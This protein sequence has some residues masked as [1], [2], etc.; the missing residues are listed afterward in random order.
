MRNQVLY[1][2]IGAAALFLVNACQK[3]VVNPPELKLP[4]TSFTDVSAAGDVVVVDY[5]LTNGVE[6]SEIKVDGDYDWAKVT[7]IK[8]ASIEVTVDPNETTEPRT[9]EFTVS[10]PGVTKDLSFSIT[11]EAGEAPAVEATVTIEPTSAEVPAEGVEDGVFV[12]TISPEGLSWEDL[13]CAVS[14]AEG[15]AGGWATCEEGDLNAD[16][17]ISYSVEPNEGEARTA[18]VTVSYPNAEDVVFTI[19]QKAAGASAEYDHEITIEV[20]IADEYS[21]TAGEDM[22]EDSDCYFFYMSEKPVD[23]GYVDGTAYFVWDIYTP[24]GT[25]GVLPAGEYRSTTDSYVP[26]TFSTANSYVTFIGDENIIYFSEGTINVTKDG[27]VYTFDAKLTDINGETYHAVY[28]GEM[29]FGGGD[30]PSDEVSYEFE[31]SYLTFYE[32]EGQNGEDNFFLALSDMPFDA[33]GYE[34][35]GCTLANFDIYAAAGTSGVLPAGTYRFDDYNYTEGTF[36]VG[37]YIRTPDKEYIYFSDGSIE[38]TKSGDD[39]VFEATLTGSKDGKTYKVSYTGPIGEGGGDEPG[40][41]VEYETYYHYLS[42]YEG[43]E[44]DEYYLSLSDMEFATDWGTGAEGSV[45]M[46][47][48]LFSAPGTG[49]VLPVGEY[50]FLNS[51]ESVAGTFNVMSE[52]TLPNGDRIRFME[53]TLDV[54]KDAEGTYTLE[55]NLAGADGVDYRITYTGPIGESSGDDPD[56]ADMTFEISVDNMTYDDYTYSIVPSNKE[57]AYIHLGTPKEVLVGYGAMSEDGVI[58]EYVLH[59]DVI[60]Q[61]LQMQDYRDKLV[62]T[63]DLTDA[64]PL[65]PASSSQEVVVLCYGIDSDDNRIT[66]VTTYKFTMQ[67]MPAV[68]TLDEETIEAGAGDYNGG[69]Y[70]SLGGDYDPEGTVTAV[71]EN[72][73]DWVRATVDP[74]ERYIEVSVDANNKPVAR[75]ATITVSHPSAAESAVLTVNQE[76]GELVFTTNPNW[77]VSYKGRESGEDG[78]YDVTSVVSTDTERFFTAVYGVDSY[79]TYGIE[80]IAENEVS[81]MEYYYGSAWIQYYSYTSSIEERWNLFDPGTYYVI[82]IGIDDEGN[83]TGLYQISD[84]FEPEQLEASD[85]YNKWLGRWTVT[86]SNGVENVLEI[87][88]RSADVS[89]TV[90]GWQ[91]GDYSESWPG[92]TANFNEDGSISFMSEEYGSYDTGQYGVGTLGCFGLIAVNDQTSTVTGGSYP[93]CTVRLTSDSTAEAVGEDITL[94][95]GNTYDIIGMEYEV[96]LSGDYEGYILNFTA[97]APLFPLTMQKADVQSAASVKSAGLSSAGRKFV[98]VRQNPVPKVLQD[99]KFGIVKAVE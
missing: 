28:T 5:T 31:Y 29:D 37:S 33:D 87:S 1:S 49:K 39:Y 81:S 74:V 93:M 94:T 11:Q 38:V 58:N 50:S 95:D 92:I 97:E 65:F 79:N 72:G 84:P 69:V 43:N 62:H 48:N 98:Q 88:T 12:Y 17:A 53:G 9:A 57:T 34:T 20:L 77:T 96:I 30:E 89:Y 68:I 25:G 86:G 18:Y 4:T 36:S 13:T 67:S 54:S 47:F 91:F 80:M 56:P 41:V 22:D 99:S 2:I 76:A 60:S 6:G 52:L 75:T 45:H 10:Y 73:V 63:G 59:D 66:P 85:E 44:Y 83:L 32:G 78:T 15:D 7:A 40:D 23:D 3:P 24:T 61:F 51:Y 42:Y 19:N 82:A 21:Y 46:Y 55:A 64:S 70:Y 35:D 27:D 16:G 14:Y 71:V 26:N 90:R 8:S